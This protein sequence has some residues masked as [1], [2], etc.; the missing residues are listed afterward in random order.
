MFASLMLHWQLTL[1][2]TDCWQLYAY[3]LC[4]Y[5][6]HYALHLKAVQK[7]N[8]SI[9]SHLNIVFT[10]SQV[11]KKLSNFVGS[12]KS[13]HNIDHAAQKTDYSDLCSKLHRQCEIS[14]HRERLHDHAVQLLDLQHP[15]MPECLSVYCTERLSRRTASNYGRRP[16][17][18]LIS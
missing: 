2:V 6:L 12:K 11:A 16:F 18:L 17:S 5:T 3:R 10:Y 4:S 7:A 14:G 15:G 13:K 1:H 8:V 9:F